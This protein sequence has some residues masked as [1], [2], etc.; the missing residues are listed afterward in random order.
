M[1]ALMTLVRPVPDGHRA[2]QPDA[3][4]FKVDKVP[5]TSSSSPC[6]HCSSRSPRSRAQRNLP[7]VL[8]LDLDHI[9]RERTMALAFTSKPAP[10][11]A[12]QVRQDPK[13]FV[14]FSASRSSAG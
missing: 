8:G 5:C 2:T 4:D 1:Y 11:S 6:R 7:A 12:D 9:G 14:I 3:V 10:S 13:L